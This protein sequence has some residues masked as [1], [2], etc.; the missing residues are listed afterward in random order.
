MVW[1]DDVDDLAAGTNLEVGQVQGAAGHAFVSLGSPKGCMATRRP[2]N[3][4]RACRVGVAKAHT[5]VDWLDVAQKAGQRAHRTQRGRDAGA[6][7]VLERLEG[8]RGGTV[9]LGVVEVALR[10][11]VVGAAS[12]Q[13]GPLAQVG[14]RP[15]IVTKVR[16]Q[17]GRVLMFRLRGELLVLAGDRRV[18]SRLAAVLG[19]AHVIGRRA[20]GSTAADGQEERCKGVPQG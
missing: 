11:S 20:R 19:G 4:E 3:L 14:G 8:A 16:G 6:L 13:I 17:A 1:R 10:G 18:P 15:S 9:R 12:E 7:C 5:A 2:R